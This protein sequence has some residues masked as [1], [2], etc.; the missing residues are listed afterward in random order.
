M[1]LRHRADA[2]EELPDQREGEAH[3]RHPAD[4]VLPGEPPAE[5][6]NKG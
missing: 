6:H 1:Q 5:E 2:R 3:G 4:G